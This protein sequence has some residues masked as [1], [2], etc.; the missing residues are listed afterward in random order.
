LHQQNVTK[1]LWWDKWWDGIIFKLKSPNYQL[2]KALSGG[3]RGI[4]TLS[5]VAALL[6]SNYLPQAG[7]Y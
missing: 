1:D 6:N 5:K 4:R 7:R 3:E 2:V